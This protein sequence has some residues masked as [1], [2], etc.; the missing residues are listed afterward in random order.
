M[1]KLGVF[2]KIQDICYNMGTEIFK[3]KE[4][5]TEKIK[6]KV[7]NRPKNWCN[8]QYLAK[9]SVTSRQCL[10]E[11]CQWP[12]LAYPCLTLA[13]ASKKNQYWM[14]VLAKWVKLLMVH[15]YTE[16]IS[17]WAMFFMKILIRVG[18]KNVESFQFTIS[19]HLSPV[20]TSNPLNPI[21]N[22]TLH[23]QVGLTLGWSSVVFAL[24]KV[25]FTNPKVT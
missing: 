2:W 19:C 1:Q 21:E 3:I 25:T 22:Y 24:K 16:W 4:K 5:M 12:S 11:T 13:W 20:T 15:T 8:S 9:F 10:L 7:A 6:P 23:E 14:F 17:R 18:L